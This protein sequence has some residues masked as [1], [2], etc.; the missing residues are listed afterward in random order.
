MQ[1]K[2]AQDVANEYHHHHLNH[3]RPQ[4]C[5]DWLICCAVVAHTVTHVRVKLRNVGHSSIG[6][7]E[8]TTWARREHGLRTTD[9]VYACVACGRIG[10]CVTPMYCSVSSRT[11]LDLWTQLAVVCNHSGRKLERIDYSSTEFLIQVYI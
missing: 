11:T 3:H 1:L 2:G 7:G 10:T 8:S 9:D 4:Y 6:Y 5:C